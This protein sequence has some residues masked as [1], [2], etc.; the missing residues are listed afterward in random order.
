MTNIGTLEIGAKI[1]T[2]EIDR[3]TDKIK[4]DMDEIGASVTS[5][6][7]DI[8][9]TEKS[10]SKLGAAFAFV[11]GIGSGIMIALASSAPALAGA[12]AKIG[13]ET[14]QLARNLGTALKPAFDIASGALSKLNEFAETNPRAFKGISLGLLGIAGGVAALKAA[15]I[16]GIATAIKGLGVALA[17]GLSPAALGIL[18][19]LAGA[20][21]G[22][23]ALKITDA[24]GFTTQEAGFGEGAKRVG[25]QAAGGAAIGAAFGSVVPGVGTAAGAIVGGIGALIFAGINEY[26]I[27]RRTQEQ[28]LQSAL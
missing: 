20:A 6:G 26:K 12:M 28:N 11:G 16:L 8:Q 4:Q 17:F 7:A 24:L 2:R 13:V 18:T 1:D 21:G 23:I 27:N 14:D 15:K 19:L 22:S 10:T 9:R 3:G 5:A 25:A